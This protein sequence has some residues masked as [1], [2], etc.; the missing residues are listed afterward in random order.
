[1]VMRVGAPGQEALLNH[2]FQ[3]DSLL[4]GSSGNR[5][6]IFPGAIYISLLELTTRVI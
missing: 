5:N 4:H 6:R 2:G 1:M 3:G